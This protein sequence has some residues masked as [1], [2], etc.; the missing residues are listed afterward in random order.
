MHCLKGVEVYFHLL[1]M[2]EQYR[3]DLGNCTSKPIAKAKGKATEFQ[4]LEWAAEGRSKEHKGK[5]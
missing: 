5:L 4:I 1:K 2:I 3:R